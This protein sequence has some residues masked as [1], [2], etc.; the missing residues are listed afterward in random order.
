MTG[1]LGA[2]LIVIFSSTLVIRSIDPVIPLIAADLA[3]DPKTA[4]LLT[5]AFSLPYALVQPVLGAAAD[6]LGKTRLMTGCVVML[7][8]A[9]VVGALAPNFAVLVGSRVIAGIVAGGIFPIGLALVGDLVPVAHRQ[10]AVGRML[11][12]GML[13]N[14]L[15]ATASGVVGDLVG[16]RGVFVGLIIL[17]II[18]AAAALIGFRGYGREQG[19]R[20]DFSS[21][22][23]NYRTIFTN[24]LAK[25][26]YGSVFI[27]G[28]FIFGLFPYVALLLFQ[29]GEEHAS[30]AGIVIGGFGVGGIIYGFIVGWLLAVFGERRLMVSGGLVMAATLVTVAFRASWP[31]DG[32]AFV[33]MGFG[34]YLLHGV[35]QI[36]ATELA[37]A[38]RGSAMSLHSFFFF[39]GQGVGPL[40]Y[41]FGLAHAGIG[42]ALI[43][44]AV[45]LVIVG[46]ICARMLR[47][48]ASKTV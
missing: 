36:Y 24:P 2:L 42:P 23:T 10:V 28:L 16:W 3:V 22:G 33:I 15:G 12:A 46:L 37:P 38:A 17:G 25:I 8:A 21:V 13:G 40:I 27:E 39:L 19:A 47:R 45:C 20:L 7:I 43:V 5:T 14:L 34:F 9:A 44:G 1:V 26:C 32:A 35:I 41:G 11:A 29:S 30:I 6:M 31:V 4:A 18:A 48:P